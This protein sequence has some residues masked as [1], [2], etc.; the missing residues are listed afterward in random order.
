M[1]DGQ[2]HQRVDISA[3]AGSAHKG[4]LQKTPEED[5]CRIIP[6]VGQGTELNRNK[7]MSKNKQHFFSTF[8]RIL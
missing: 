3:H 1:L 4:L 8:R 5:L 2:Q 6:Q 7:K